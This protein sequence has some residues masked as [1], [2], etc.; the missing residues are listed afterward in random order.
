MSPNHE[1]A[2][3]MFVGVGKFLMAS[4]ICFIGLIPDW[5]SVKPAKST[6]SSAKQN[7]LG[8]NTMPLLLH[9]VIY[10][11]VCQN[12]P[13]MLISHRRESSIHLAFLLTSIVMLSKALVYPSPAA[14]KPCGELR[15]L[16]LPHSV[17]NVVASLA[18]GAND[19]E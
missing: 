7:F 8:L 15:Y 6:S 1:R 11:T 2:P 3:V 10:S 5:V 16:Y 9:I 19:N 18:D 12:A 17:M 4:K 14:W 13:S